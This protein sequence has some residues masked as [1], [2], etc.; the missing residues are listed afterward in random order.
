MQNKQKFVLHV[1]NTVL[2]ISLKYLLKKKQGNREKSRNFEWK[3]SKE[4]T[5]IMK[6]PFI[7]F[8]SEGL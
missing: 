5:K 1:R 8:F 3:D 4:K 6:L 7:P 2:E